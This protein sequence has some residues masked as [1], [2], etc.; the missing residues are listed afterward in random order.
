MP[1]IPLWQLDR[2]VAFTNALQILDEERP[3][4]GST[5]ELDPLRLFDTVEHWRLSRK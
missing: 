1:F 2:H 4:I 3:L 5:P